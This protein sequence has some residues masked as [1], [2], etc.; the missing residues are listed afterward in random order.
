MLLTSGLLTEGQAEHVRDLARR[1]GRTDI[2]ILQEE[3][4]VDSEQLA[5]V[6]SLHMGVPLINL[7]QQEAEDSAIELFPEWVCRKYRVLPVSTNNGIV[8][9]AMEDPTD[10]QA[11]DDLSAVCK[12]NIEAALAFSVDIMEGIDR[13]YRIGGEVATQLLRLPTML[14]QR[15]DAESAEEAAEAIA[16]AP[17]VRAVDLLIRQAARDR[18]SDIHIEPQGDQLQVRFRIDGILH[19]GM[20]LPMAVHS[21]LISRLKIIA[22]MNIAETRRPQDGQ[23]TVNDG[24]REL[25][26]RVATVPTVNGEM[27]VLRI[28]DKTFAFRALHELGFLPETLKAYVGLLKLPY[29][30]ILASGPTGSGKTTTLY[31]SINQLDHGSSKIITIEDPVEYRFDKI[32]QI[33]VNPA[34][35]V[36]FPTGLRATMRLDPN[37]IL[38]GEIRDTETA[39]VAIQAALTGHLLLSSV[40]ANDT[41]GVIFRLIDL[42]IEP[43]LLASAV[44]GVV[45][46][47]MVRRICP[48]CATL[49]TVT[50]E[51]RLGYEQEMGEEREQFLTP[52]GC[53][54][55]AQTGYL[56]RTGIYEIMV[57]TEP[58]RR[59]I[60]A[61]GNIDDIRELAVKEGMINLWRDGMIKVKMG[62]TTPHEVSRN[63]FSIS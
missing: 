40:H 42:G 59:M 4:L 47:R 12:K 44:A 32:A 10:I 34:A 41:A 13:N 20:S 31:G 6:A 17:V 19:E 28:L 45:A 35:G 11:I 25:D 14:G 56:G 61:G 22:G 18:A 16:E 5:L 38:V 51:E 43:F 50:A 52:I 48:N 26:I 7:K 37:V 55:C 33:Q 49:G 36:T 9:A 3:Q 1:E 8:R 2:S 46:Q 15:A 30:M 29:G 58:V 54:Y 57:V 62:I 53:N 21:A 60:L 63:V 24:E 27:A 39:Q 23:I